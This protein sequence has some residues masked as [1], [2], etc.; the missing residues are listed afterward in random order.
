M[1]FRRG[2]LWIALV[3]PACIA[4][5]WL[6]HALLTD[7]HSTSL[8]VSLALLNGIP[9]AAINGLMLWMFARTLRPPREPLITAFAR[10][11]HGTLPPHIERYTRHVTAMWCVF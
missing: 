8:R 1:G 11:V 6:V 3:P 9:H 10:R 2:W 5:Q 7:A 4:Y